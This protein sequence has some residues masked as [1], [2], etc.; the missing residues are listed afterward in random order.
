MEKKLYSILFS[1]RLM[2][3]LFLGF[4]VA[5]AAGTFIESKYNTD[6]ARIWVYNAWWF[7]AIMGFFMINFLGNIKRY[8]L[9]K[10]EKWLTLLL[11]LSW[12]FII[13]GAFTAAGLMIG[14]I[15]YLY[16]GKKER[17]MFQDSHFD[18][19]LDQRNRAIK[20]VYYGGKKENME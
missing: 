2:A 7:E 6:T 10:K 12:I 9:Y 11:H 13:G 15:N 3:L 17:D 16:E 20:Q 8:R 19:R 14:G 4:A 18:H 5:M 1:T